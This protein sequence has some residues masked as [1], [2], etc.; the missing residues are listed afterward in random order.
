VAAG[1]HQLLNSSGSRSAPIS[2]KSWTVLQAAP[3]DCW[4]SATNT[5]LILG[6]AGVPVG[7]FRAHVTLKVSYIFLLELAAAG[8]RL[9]SF[10]SCLPSIMHQC[11]HTS[12]LD[13]S[14]QLQSGSRL[15]LLSQQG[16]GGGPCNRPTVMAVGLGKLYVISPCVPSVL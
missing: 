7:F 13:C 14:K 5:A 8:T 10:A 11:L 6:G 3:K 16:C 12:N 15:L 4:D 9:R 2:D 1:L